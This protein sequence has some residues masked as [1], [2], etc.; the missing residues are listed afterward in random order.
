VSEARA[1][2]IR[3]GRQ[4]RFRGS[5]IEL[6]LHRTGAFGLLALGAPGKPKA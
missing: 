4:P 3:I 1:G 5:A 6:G 2:P